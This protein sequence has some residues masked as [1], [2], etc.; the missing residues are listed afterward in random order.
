MT[1]LNLVS[2]AS[3]N[4]LSFG[5]HKA[6]TCTNDYFCQLDTEKQNLTIS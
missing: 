5:R 1:T 3:G 2:I 4:A 6:I